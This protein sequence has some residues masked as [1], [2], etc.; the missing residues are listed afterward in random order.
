MP[1]PTTTDDFLDLV[2]KSEL[3]DTEALDACVKH[4][5]A[6]GGI[7]EE[8]K[9]LA[10]ILVREGI[11][12][13]FQAE[14]LLAGRWR[15]FDIGKYK[16]LERLGSGGGSNVY[17]C[18]H[19]G[20]GNRVA[21]KVLYS[22]KA[23]DP[24]MV[25]RF[26]REARAA[27]TLNHP[28]IVRGFDLDEADNLNFLVMEYIE[29]NSLEKIIRKLGP[30]DVFRA[31]HYIKQAAQGLKH[32]HEAGVVHRD[33]KPANLLLDRAGTL[34][35]LD[36][37]LARFTQ[38]ENFV[39][40]QKET[41]LGT[42]DYVAPEQTRDSHRVDIRADLYSLGAT[43]YFLL[44]GRTPFPKGSIAQKLVWLQTQEPPSVSMY[45]PEVPEELVKIIEKMMAKDPLKRYQT[46]SEVIKALEAWTRAPIGPPPEAEMPRMSRVAQGT[47]SGNIRR[48]SPAALAQAKQAAESQQSSD[49]T[50]D[51]ITKT[52]APPPKV[53]PEAAKAKPAAAK[54]PPTMEELAHEESQEE[55]PRRKSQSKAGGPK[56]VPVLVWLFW[57]GMGLV[58]AAAIGGLIWKTF[59]NKP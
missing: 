12:A 25:E 14:Q 31:C 18:E 3:V 47:G 6:N 29:G 19:S 7:P 39:L 50:T 33:I 57:I 43:F 22:D 44:T 32:A 10:G 54:G 16:V 46:P 41:V 38:E 8:P 35:I 34:K 9:K 48:P 26:R 28:N 45:R 1:A 56:V 13:L 17:L 23:T 53:R 37:G 52:P 20:M 30:M 5:R 11:L 36:M 21:V 42:A 58:L 4:M 51:S 2:R 49:T 24:T 55:D 15:G 59:L 27:A 40:T